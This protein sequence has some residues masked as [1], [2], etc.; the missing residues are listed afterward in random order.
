M[1]GDRRVMRGCEWYGFVEGRMGVQMVVTRVILG[2]R[3]AEK[4]RKTS[5]TTVANMRRR[6]VRGDGLLTCDAHVK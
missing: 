1:A 2:G 6:T 3:I 5:G 4:E